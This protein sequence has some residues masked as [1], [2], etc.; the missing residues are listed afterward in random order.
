MPLFL[1]IHILKNWRY[2]V[3]LK[4]RTISPVILS[5][6][7]ASALYKGIDY[8]E[9]N[10][11]CNDFSIVY[12]FFSYDNRDG[13]C[14]ENFETVNSYYIPGSSLKGSILINKNNN[15][16]NSDDE[17]LFRR[18]VIFRDILLEKNQIALTNLWKFQYLYQESKDDSESS[19]NPKYGKFFPAVGIEMLKKDVCF[20]GSILIKNSDKGFEEQFINKLNEAV[21]ITK[22]KLKR[23]S[24]EIDIRIEKIKELN[25]A[26]SALSSAV[27]ELEK[28]K[29]SINELIGQDKKYIF[30]GGYKGILGSLIKIEN[31]N[32]RNGFYID[33]E[34]F[35]PYGIVE[36]ISWE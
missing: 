20:N 2:K 15:K 3:K 34:T 28:I 33:N 13:K 24:N 7:S 23:Y 35:L 31:E 17:N 18:S 36:V 11:G 6:R 25:I 32:I 1:E 16:N 10:C 8:K 29:N 22:E 9:I 5:G 12:P 14:N 30:L 21:C 27:K 4:F 19:K 26:H